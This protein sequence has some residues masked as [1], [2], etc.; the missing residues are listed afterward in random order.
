V[1]DL[2][3]LYRNRPALHELDCDPSGFSIAAPT[4]ADSGLLSFF[5]Y[6]TE[7]T[8]ILAIYNF[9]PVPRSNVIAPVPVGGRWTELLNSD[10]LAYGGSGVGN[11]GGVDAVEGDDGTWHLAL[12][13][14]PLACIFLGHG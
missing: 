14:P 12:T 8:P 2:N 1:T 3:A 9:T 7:G 5:R 11:L 10:A 13:V 6:A 4:D